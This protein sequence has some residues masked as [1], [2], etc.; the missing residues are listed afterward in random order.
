M[1]NN[2]Q[3]GTL[4]TN[5]SQINKVTP[6]ETQVVLAKYQF[7]YSTLGLILGLAAIIGGIYLFI[8]GASGSMDWE[9]NIMGAESNL[10][11]AAPGALLFIVGLFMV[12]VTRYKYKHIVAK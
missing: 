5:S 8:Q 12:F 11:Q 10:V 7:L 4:I 2:N 6:H 3:K 9:I 1:K